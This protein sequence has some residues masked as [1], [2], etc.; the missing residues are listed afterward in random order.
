MSHPVSAL[1]FGA[2]SVVAL[3]SQTTATGTQS[4]RGAIS[5]PGTGSDQVK[6]L[7]SQTTTTGTKSYRGV[8]S[9]PGCIAGPLEA[10]ARQT[11]V[12]GIKAS[13]G[14]ISSP[15]I[16][17]VVTGVPRPP[18]PVIPDPAVVCGDSEGTTKV[19]AR[20]PV[21]TAART[22][23]HLAG[24]T[25]HTQATRYILEER[26]SEH[27]NY[28][29]TRPTHALAVSAASFQRESNHEKNNLSAQRIIQ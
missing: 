29:R 16:E 13:R 19:S 27:M 24:L 23:L 14:A 11:T 10:R 15:G 9:S 21:E 5:A 2:G 18:G 20:S 1:G 22:C 8:A 26:R 28:V 17:P 3:A 25:G 7:A 4:S 6:A 12:I